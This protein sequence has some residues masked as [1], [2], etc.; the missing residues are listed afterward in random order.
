VHR[1]APVWHNRRSHSRD[2]RYRLVEY[3]EQRMRMGDAE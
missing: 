1:A 2:V 3:V